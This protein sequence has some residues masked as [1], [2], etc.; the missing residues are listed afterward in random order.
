MASDKIQLR[1]ESETHDT[2]GCGCDK[3]IREE[4]EA[5]GRQTGK[6]LNIETNWKTTTRQRMRT[7]LC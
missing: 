7:H 4:G 3:R 1:P 6:H 2:L 5:S